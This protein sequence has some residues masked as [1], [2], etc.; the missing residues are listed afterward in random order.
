[1][2]SHR[3]GLLTAVLAFAPGLA[4]AAVSTFDQ[5]LISQT[6]I[7]T[8][9][10]SDGFGSAL[11][12]GDFDGD[13]YP[14]LAVGAPGETF[15]GVTSSGA[16]S[17]YYG[18]PT[19]L[20][21]VQGL[22]QGAGT[23]PGV[24]DDYAFF[25]RTLA[26][27]DFDDDGRDDLA[28]GSWSDVG[29]ASQ[30]GTVTVLYGAPGGLG[31]LGGG[32]LWSQATAGVPG[33]PE[34][35]E[36]FGDELASGDFDGDG[37]ADLAI[38]SQRDSGTAPGMG[39]VTVLYGGA[40]GLSVTGIDFYTGDSLGCS[41]AQESDLFGGAVA[42][43][44]FN[45][46]GEDD[47]AIGVPGESHFPGGQVVNSAGMVFVVPGSP[48]GLV[49]G[50]ALCLYPGAAI[51]GGTVPGSRLAGGSFGGSLAAGNFDRVTLAGLIHDDLA[52]GN[53]GVM[54]SA[55]PQAGEVVVLRG[56]VSGLNASGA[57][58]FNSHDIPGLPP[59]AL[60][61]FFGLG[62]RAARASGGASDD[63]LLHWHPGGGSA[64][65]Y[66][67]IVVPGSSTG[68]VLGRALPLTSSQSFLLVAPPEADDRFGGASGVADFDQDG[69]ADIALG[70]P[71]KDLPMASGAGVVLVLQGTLF[72]D[73]FET[74]DTRRW[75]SV[76]P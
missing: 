64:P 21:S 8:P 62:L 12:V 18:A 66:G 44:D 50:S 20:G 26:A 55:V 57:F 74:A 71:G 70:T 51:A 25:G 40:A 9:E 76:A 35:Q 46:D 29:A 17:I 24:L 59:A 1:M 43:G 75:S 65:G 19:G 60:S 47:L 34:V 69:F 52:I 22:V 4:A 48:S 31:D 27:G 53:Y 10:S 14:D 15:G 38:G 28:I 49:A 5:Q 30:A 36:F 3:I 41:A 63:L 11:A 67:L 42:A 54:I 2:T 7:S 68:L 45:A 72:S 32:Q 23:V 61:Q 73:N 56:G 58:G 16:L 13:G 6:V 39:S 37:F 33:T